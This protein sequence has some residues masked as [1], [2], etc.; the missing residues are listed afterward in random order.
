MSSS[1]AAGPRSMRAWRREPTN[2]C[3][4]GGASS[5]EVKSRIVSYVNQGLA[6]VH[7]FGAIL[8]SE[9]SDW[10]LGGRDLSAP[11]IIHYCDAV[12]LMGGFQ[13]TYRAANWG[14]IEHKPLLPIRSFGGAAKE[15]CLE[16]A[17]RVD[18][19]YAGTVSRSKYEAVLK[20]L[21]TNWEQIVADVVNLAVAHGIQLMRVVFV[22]MT[23]QTSPQFTDLLDSIRQT[24]EEFGYAAYW[25]D[26]TE[27]GERILRRSSVASASRHS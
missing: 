25:V 13:G 14:R 8:Q 1:T 5:D 22:V 19:V 21:S 3:S 2:R 20:S 26:E 11:E 15:I 27:H 7:G 4:A 17:K 12:V 6:P 23:F 16:V 24:C 10:E 18:V 9:L